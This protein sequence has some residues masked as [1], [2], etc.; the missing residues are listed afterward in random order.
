MKPETHICQSCK[1]DF[2]IEIDDLSFYEKIKSPAPSWCPECRLIRRLSF[3]NERYLYKRPCELCK[4]D[5]LSMYNPGVKRK[6]F[7]PACWWSDNWDA[8]ESAQE[9]D[10]SKPFFE[11]FKELSEK[12]PVQSLFLSYQNIV[13]SDYNN[14]AGYLKECYMVFHADHNERCMYASGLKVCNDS[15]DVLMLQ[16]S[17]LCYECTN[18]TKGYRNFYS[19]DC[20][21]C[22]DVWFS[23]NCMNCQDCIGC[24]NL[25]NQQ[26][27]IFNEQY[28]KEDYLAKRETLS[29]NTYDGIQ[30]CQ[31]EARKLWIKYPQKY[32]HS[33]NNV[34]STGDYVFN[35]KNTLASYEMVGAEDCK[36]CQFDSTK[37]TK[38]CYDYTEYGEN[39]EL[40]Y[41][42]LLVGD[43]C[44]DVRFSTQ[45]VS[46]VRDVEYCYGLTSSAH[47]F[48]C[49]GLHNAEY[50]I[51]NKQ[52]T[53]EEYEELVPKIRDHMKTMPYVDAHGRTY[54]YGEFFPPELSSFGYNES[55]AQEFFPLDSTKAGELGY[56]WKP[57][58]E[59]KYI[60]TKTWKELPQTL[61]ETP[62]DITKEIILCEAWDTNEESAKNH[63]CTKAYRILPQ[64]FLFYKRL[65]LPLPRKCPNSRH[66]DRT[67]DRQPLKLWERTCM[68]EVNTHDHS[69]KCQ[70]NFK[71]SYNPERKE[72]IY[73]E[74]CYQKEVM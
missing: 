34:N 31:A 42:A 74:A 3:R 43:S 73:C 50:R 66:F 45:C 6:I 55:T 32:M 14:L 54:K 41:E 64:E 48:G 9:Y 52:Y 2:L 51:L 65:N 15:M 67:Q 7:C 28:S 59:K 47:L 19:V 53:K 33:R 10:F 22:S 68:C 18:V 58:E 26:Y 61:I 16:K 23:K 8:H 12:A 27:C 20:E 60:P 69:G 44:A 72:I 70:N 56:A 25:R 38:D 36:Y 49:I 30:K 35:S 37:T 39:V 17:D 57:T 46:N 24:V 4:K 63:N 5:G 62:S 11:Q 71:T 13:N 29:L 21:E 1:K 40:A